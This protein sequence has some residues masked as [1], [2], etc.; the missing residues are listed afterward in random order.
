MV[1]LAWWLVSA[2]PALASGWSIQPT[3]QP[4]AGTY[5]P[6][7]LRG[8]SCPSSSVCI[9]VGNRSVA[10]NGLPLAER[11]NGT[12]W[13]IESIEPTPNLLSGGLTGVSCAS[14]TACS[15]VGSYNTTAGN[16]LTLA[17]RWNGI[18]WSMQRTPNP[19]GATY[20]ELFGVSCASPIACTAV[21]DYRNDERQQLALVERWN[22]ISWSIQPTPNPAGATISELN[23]VSC[24]SKTCTA[25]GGGTPGPL[26]QLT[27]AERWNGA[28]WSIQPTPNPAGSTGSLLYGVSCAS[29]DRRCTA[30]GS[31][32]YRQLVERWNGKRW[33]VRRTPSPAGEMSSALNGVSCASPKACTAV[34]SYAVGAGCSTFQPPCSGLPLV[35]R[36]NGHQLVDAAHPQ[37]RRRDL[38]PPERRVVRF[39]DRLHRRGQLHRQ[40]RRRS[41]A[42]RALER[43]QLTGD[44]V[45]RAINDR[46]LS[47]PLG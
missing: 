21:G 31:Y 30:V 7:K 6:S 22:G 32:N 28:R 16:Q 20:S 37:P 10:G 12:S 9:A 1:T 11:W 47:P 33:S 25:V 27:L 15:A 41:D 2:S 39:A 24:A 35:E 42:C 45:P 44:T 3:P 4:P 29:T 17:A 19:A 5:S 34:G 13:S 40:P 18:S 36:W 23:G 14:P 43:P 38:H 46:R 26:G 8:V